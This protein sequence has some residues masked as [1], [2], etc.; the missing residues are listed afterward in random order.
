VA[1]D[2]EAVTVMTDAE[3]VTVTAAHE[4][5]EEEPKSA[6]EEEEPVVDEVVAPEEEFEVLVLDNT[7]NVLVELL[8][9]ELVVVPVV[10]AER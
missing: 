7:E 8:E 1:T 2:T 5:A 4:E 9:L 10:V 6:L 3:A